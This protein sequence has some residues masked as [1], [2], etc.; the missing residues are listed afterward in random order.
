MS[1]KGK[2]LPNSFFRANPLMDMSAA[3]IAHF[4]ITVIMNEKLEQ[5]IS[6]AA[7]QGIDE[8]R[9]EKNPEGTK[10]HRTDG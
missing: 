9:K 6:D 10:A 2:R 4:S 7:A 1:T 3:M 5:M 8:E